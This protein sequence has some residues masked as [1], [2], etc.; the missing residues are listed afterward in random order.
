MVSRWFALYLSGTR[1][2]NFLRATIVEQDFDF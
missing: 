1:I 2:T